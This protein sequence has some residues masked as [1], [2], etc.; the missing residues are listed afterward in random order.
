MCMC[1]YMCACII[2][3]ADMSRYLVAA[4]PWAP[5]CDA[6]VLSQAGRDYWFS[7]LLLRNLI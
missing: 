7:G 4:G 6:H 3:C 2:M 1:V 5:C